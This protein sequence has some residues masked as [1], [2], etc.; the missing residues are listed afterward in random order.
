MQQNVHSFPHGVIMVY[1]GCFRVA[2]CQKLYI[3]FIFLLHAQPA[4]SLF[5]FFITT[6]CTNDMWLQNRV[7]KVVTE[8]VSGMETTI[9]T[10]VFA[11]NSNLQRRNGLQVAVFLKITLSQSYCRDFAKFSEKVYVK[12]SREAENSEQ[13]IL[14]NFGK[15][16]RHQMQVIFTVHTGA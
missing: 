3:K 9:I 10:N 8:N 5:C 15:I 11:L 1:I 12:S 6:C 4:T 13:R 7:V 2:S 14:E 16:S